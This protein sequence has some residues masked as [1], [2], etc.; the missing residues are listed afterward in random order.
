MLRPD[1]GAAEL[2]ASLRD[3]RTDFGAKLAT[4]LLKRLVAGPTQ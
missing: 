1:P 4:E 3:L 2:G